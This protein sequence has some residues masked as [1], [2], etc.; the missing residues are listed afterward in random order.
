MLV[1]LVWSTQHT[2]VFITNL[3]M[4]HFLS[5]LV[6]S[7]FLSR[8]LSQ[9]HTK[10]LYYVGQFKTKN[11]SFVELRDLSGSKSGDPRDLDL[12]VTNFAESGTNGISAFLDI[13]RYL[14][15]IS[16]GASPPRTVLADKTLT[17]YEI[18]YTH[19]R[20]N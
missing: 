13:G 1:C 12:V 9:S 11:P 6:L 5:L 17:W 18:M 15:N 19:P 2:Q 7:I 20:S 8:T 16:N 10:D 3:S 4:P 14:R